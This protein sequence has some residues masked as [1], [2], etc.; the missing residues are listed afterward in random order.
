MFAALIYRHRKLW[1][2]RDT[3]I[4]INRYLTRSNLLA[5]RF[6]SSGTR[7]TCRAGTWTMAAAAW[8]VKTVTK[9]SA[10]RMR[11]RRDG[12]KRDKTETKR[13]VR[14]IR[15]RIFWKRGREHESPGG[16]RPCVR[17]YS[18]IRA[19]TQSS[20]GALRG[21]VPRALFPPVPRGRLFT[22]FSVND[23]RPAH[24]TTSDDI[25]PGKK[26]K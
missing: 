18:R 24:A 13:D 26:N 19:R 11:P 4:I 8:R 23:S 7:P 5:I 14:E 16:T 20:G 15:S 3:I 22:Y 25:S 2:M 12:I 21:P 9:S 6:F 1:N 10:R 17:R